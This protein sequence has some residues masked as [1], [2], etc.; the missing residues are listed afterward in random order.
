MLAWDLADIWDALLLIGVF[1][2][3]LSTTSTNRHV[4]DEELLG[5]DYE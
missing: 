4:E 2:S 1:L 3:A 5:W